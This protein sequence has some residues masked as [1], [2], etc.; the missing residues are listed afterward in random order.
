[1]TN[2]REQKKCT[3]SPADPTGL[4]LISEEYYHFKVLLLAADPRSMRISKKTLRP[5]GIEVLEAVSETD[6]LNLLKKESPDLIVIDADLPRA[7]GFDFCVSLRLDPNIG[8]IPIIFLV[9]SLSTHEQVT[10][11]ESGADGLLEKP[12]DPELLL[13]YVINFLKRRSG[14]VENFRVLRTLGRYISSRAR[15]KAGLGG[16]EKIHATILFSDMRGFTEKTLNKRIEDIF[17]SISDLASRQITIVHQFGGYIDKFTGD[18]LLAV[19]DAQSHVLDACNAALEIVDSFENIKGIPLGTPPPIG[20]GINCGE[21]LRG[22]I[23]GPEHMD[24]SVI[25]STV[26]LAA[27]LCGQAQSL[28]IIVSK[29][30]ADTVKG[31]LTTDGGRTVR[32]KGVGSTRIY[33]LKGRMDEPGA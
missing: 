3:R 33:R 4:R 10:A 18:G 29:A 14:E 5:H 22:N 9:S 6:A 26:N 24:F 11:M 20:M 21:L 25:G 23:G 13:A 12:I 7:N 31:I 30:V 17:K 2:A 8:P 32:L 27:R 1:M 19:F 15:E 28:E 16:T